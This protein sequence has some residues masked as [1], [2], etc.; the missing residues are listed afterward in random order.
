MFIFSDFDFGEDVRAACTV[1]PAAVAYPV[2]VNIMKMKEEDGKK[3]LIQAY[4]KQLDKYKLSME[5]ILQDGEPE[6][7]VYKGEMDS[8]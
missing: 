6:T 8:I 7:V 2:T 4:L 3:E 5:S 1:V